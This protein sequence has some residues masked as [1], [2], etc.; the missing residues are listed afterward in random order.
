MYDS[1][2][3]A[4]FRL[5]NTFVE[6][7]GNLKYVNKVGGQDDNIKLLLHGVE[8]PVFLDDPKLNILRP[9]VGY[10][11]VGG[12][13]I[14]IARTPNRSY[15]QGLREDNVRV[16]GGNLQDFNRPNG[17]FDLFNDGESTV[18]N[19]DF[20]VQDKTLLYKG[21]AVG[22]VINHNY[23]LSNRFKFLQEALEE[24]TNV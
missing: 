9:R 23:H 2:R 6:Y 8:K 24:A 11:Q 19:K 15:R 16:I 3:Q 17:Y 20:A 22:M 10:M 18:I 5:N 21:D 7:D 14:Y 1:V 12:K 13:L 4:S